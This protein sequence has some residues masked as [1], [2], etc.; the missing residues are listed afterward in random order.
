MKDAP[1]IKTIHDITDSFE[2][3]IESTI[4][5]TITKTKHFAEEVSSVIE[6]EEEDASENDEGED[7]EEKE[8][9]NVKP[10]Q[11][12]EAYVKQNT[13]TADVLITLSVILC[14]LMSLFPSLATPCA[15]LMLPITALL[16]FHDDY[17]VLS[18]IVI[19]FTDQL[20]IAVGAPIAREYKYILLIRF[21]MYDLRE[22]K[23]RT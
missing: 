3:K 12:S 11:G 9:K 14:A 10:V 7:G 1:N 15:I 22:L 16:F 13:F 5:T 20:I 21:F 8:K 17:Y 19:F 18:A 23:L 2:E 6:E 4:E